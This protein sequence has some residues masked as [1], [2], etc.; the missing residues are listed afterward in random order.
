MLGHLMETPA[1]SVS[2]GD[3]IKQRRKALDLTQERLAHQVGCSVV[4]IRK[5]ESEE[6]RPSRQ[7]ASLMAQALQIPSEEH[8]LFIKIA[9]QERDFIHLILLLDT[10]QM[11]EIH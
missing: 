6:R 10:F 9:R 4:L 11:D 3:W 5:I 7:I 2:F 1:F 8:E